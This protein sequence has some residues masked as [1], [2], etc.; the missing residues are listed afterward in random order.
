MTSSALSLGVAFL[1]YRNS[2]NVFS[3]FTGD[4]RIL[5][6]VKMVLLVDMFLEVGRWE[7]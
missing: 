7:S 3:I 2:W 1:L 4:K 6:L 5:E